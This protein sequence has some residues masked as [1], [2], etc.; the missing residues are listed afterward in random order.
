LRLLL[1]YPNE[2]SWG[3][4]Y[5]DKELTVVSDFIDQ[6]KEGTAGNSYLFDW[7][8]PYH[9]QS[10]L[11]SYSVPKYFATDYFQRIPDKVWGKDSSGYKHSWPS[12][13]IGTGDTRS[14]LHVDAV[15]SHFWMAM[16]SGRK[17]W[18]IVTP[19]HVPFLYPNPNTAT[20]DIGDIFDVDL[21]RYP[22]ASKA[23][24]WETI[25]EAGDLIFVPGGSAHQIRNL[26]TIVAISMNFIDEENVARALPLLQRRYPGVVNFVM[27]ASF[28]RGVPSN[29]RDLPWALY[30]KFPR[31]YEY[32]D[33]L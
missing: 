32:Y 6:V 10:I 30:K 7:G 5:G 29:Q 20:F 2:Q 27:S 31:P 23:K 26:D 12:L 1:W 22:L 16:I 4:L 25:I 3:N 19:D 24:I 18:G 21:A 11:E 14:G 28:P 8:L 13:F 33:L 9:C 17:R 15:Q